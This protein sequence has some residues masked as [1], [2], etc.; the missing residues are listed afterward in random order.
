MAAAGRARIEQ[1]K[2]IA[3]A[4]IQKNKETALTALN[5][6]YANADKVK[7]S[8]G[9]IGITF[10]VVLFGSIFMN[11][12]IKLCI[13]YWN[14]LR[15]WWRG[16][17]NDQ[18]QLNNRNNQIVQEVQIEMDRVYGEDL[19]EKLERVYIKLLEVNVNRKRNINETQALIF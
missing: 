2:Q 15:E 16:N 7:T 17:E 4:N 8:F 11:D 13:Y 12:L 19:E 9:Y 18:E 6:Q 10:L 1:Q 14:G 3:L 5:I